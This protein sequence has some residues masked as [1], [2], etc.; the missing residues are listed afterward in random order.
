MIYTVCSGD[1]T[2][3]I[4]IKKLDIFDFFDYIEKYESGRRRTHSKGR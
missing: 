3:M 2:N 4:E 1:V